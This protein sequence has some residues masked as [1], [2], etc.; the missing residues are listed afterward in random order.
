MGMFKNIEHLSYDIILCSEE[1]VGCLMSLPP[2]YA[3]EVMFSSFLCVCVCVCA[4]L[5]Y[6]F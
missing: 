1:I 6:N 4:S 5:G 3:I 2:A